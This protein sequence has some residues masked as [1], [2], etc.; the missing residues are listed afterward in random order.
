M[1]KR[2][3][4]GGLSYCTTGNRKCGGVVGQ[5]MDKPITSVGIKSNTDFH[6]LNCTLKIEYRYAKD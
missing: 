6:L 2:I 1:P 4:S 5:R 3:A